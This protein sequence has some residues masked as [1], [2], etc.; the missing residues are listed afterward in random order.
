[1]TDPVPQSGTFTVGQCIQQH[2]LCVCVCGHEC[3]CAIGE[4]VVVIEWCVC[5]GGG[6]ECNVLHHFLLSHFDDELIRLP[7]GQY[8]T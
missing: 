8:R 7:R 3:V 2:L 5:V 1:M 4:E 6:G